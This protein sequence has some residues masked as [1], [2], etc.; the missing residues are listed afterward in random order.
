MRERLAEGRCVDPHYDSAKWNPGLDL[1]VASSAPSP[2]CY[3]ATL[4]LLRSVMTRPVEAA[5]VENTVPAER[6]NF[7]ILSVLR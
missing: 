1:L 3:R 4:S 6:Y 5:A 2:L 7:I